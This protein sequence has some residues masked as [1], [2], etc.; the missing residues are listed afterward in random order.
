MQKLNTRQIAVLDNAARRS[1]GQLLPLPDGMQL[2]GG[3]LAA[4]LR[5]LERRGL[6]GRSADGAWIITEAGRAAVA[7]QGRAGVDESKGEKKTLQTT[8]SEPDEVDTGSTPLFRPGTRQ[9]QL[10]DLL[11]RGE[12]A[13]IDE[14]VQFTGWQPHSVRAVLTGFRKRGIEVSRTKEGNGVSV[15]RAAPPASADG[16]AA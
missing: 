3:G 9:A 16:M 5:A 4:M 15:Y 13:D 6:A 2:K 12:G 7:V 10:L 14:M 1:D 11:R 8:K